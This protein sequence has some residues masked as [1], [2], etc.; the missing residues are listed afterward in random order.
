VK[1]INAENEEAYLDSLHNR[2]K[3]VLGN[4]MEVHEGIE[5]GKKIEVDTVEMKFD[6]ICWLEKTDSGDKKRYAILNCCK[7]A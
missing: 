7:L 2:L 5:C 3:P 6:I 4:L 1:D